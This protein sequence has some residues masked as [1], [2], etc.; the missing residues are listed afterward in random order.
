MLWQYPGVVFR[1]DYIDNEGMDEI[2]A[3]AVFQQILSAV[4]YCHSN[5]VVR[6]STPR[7]L[8]CAGELD[9]GRAGQGLFAGAAQPGDGSTTTV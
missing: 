2:S 3:R 5:A 6:A 8:R 7:A 9:R 1:H 4:H